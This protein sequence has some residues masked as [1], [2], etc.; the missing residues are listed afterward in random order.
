M[1]CCEIFFLFVLCHILLVINR[2]KPLT[3]LV[4][5]LS[6]SGKLINM[7]F[8][9]LYKHLLSLCI[10]GT[11][12]INNITQNISFGDGQDNKEAANETARMLKQAL[13]S[14]IQEEQRPGGLLNRR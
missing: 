2:V 5:F 7:I 8:I 1:N 11:P 6:K 4:A 12:I 14:V 3:H 10:Q 9:E 13:R